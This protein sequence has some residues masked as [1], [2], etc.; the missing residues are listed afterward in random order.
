MVETKKPFYLFVVGPTASG[1]SQFAME[2]AEKY[3]WPIIN[4]DS[5]QVYKK[6]DIGTAK[7]T[8]E[9]MREVPHLLFDFVD[10][11][12]TLTAADYIEEVRRITLGNQKQNSV[13]V[14][15]S[16]FYI[17][18]LEKGLYPNAKVPEE[19]KAR[20]KQWI[21]DKGYDDLYTWIKERDREFADKI[22]A[23]DHYR[24]RR[25]GEI[26]FSQTK[27]MT[28]LKAQMKSQNLS[29]LPDHRKLKIGFRAEKSILKERVQNR[30]QQMLS[31]G[32][33]EEVKA[34][35]DQGL[36][37]WP[38]LK[39]V[40]YKEVQMLLNGEIPIQSLEDQIVT[41]T[42]QLIKKQMTW[43]KRD[44]QIKWFDIADHDSA[45]IEVEEFLKNYSGA[46]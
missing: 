15:G 26:M 29:V 13:F 23:N 41:A 35:L 38:P 17:Q 39:S 34:L 40:G 9:E 4:C 2:V 20:V 18:A 45:L 32:L 28:E 33:V 46:E 27:T 14:G 44:Q 10:P 42:M 30:T 11:P 1:K 5:L 8:K 43:F 6:T 16:G 12:N 31:D 37:D 25:A 22:S 36:A 3:Q 24:I 7:P 21:E 19:A